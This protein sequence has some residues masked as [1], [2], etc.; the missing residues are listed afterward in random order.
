MFNILSVEIYLLAILLITLSP[1]FYILVYI[2]GLDY[3]SAND[4]FEKVLRRVKND[5]KLY[6]THLMGLSRENEIL[7]SVL[8]HNQNFPS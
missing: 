5:K 4:I 7:C 6:S 1:R 2:L 3:L 8:G